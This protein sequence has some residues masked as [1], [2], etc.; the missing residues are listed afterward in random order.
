[1]KHTSKHLNDNEFVALICAE[2]DEDLHN[3]DAKLIER[4]DST[5][6]NALQQECV[7]R[8][9]DEEL[10]VQIARESLTDANPLNEDIESQLDQIRAQAMAHLAKQGGREKSSPLSDW[11]PHLPWRMPASVFA[12]AFAI[13]GTVALLNIYNRDA[14]LQGEIEL[15]MLTSAEDLELYENLEFYLWLSENELVSQ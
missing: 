3:L 11:L 4:L 15:A 12:S 2:L 6:N 7:S 14:G 5:R 8:S 10:L 13:V 1:M 9:Q